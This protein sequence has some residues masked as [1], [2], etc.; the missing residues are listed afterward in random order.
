MNIVHIKTMATLYARQGKCKGPCNPNNCPMS[1]TISPNDV[2]GCCDNCEEDI[3]KCSL[4]QGN[5]TKCYCYKYAERY[6]KRVLVVEEI[7]S[8]ALVEYLI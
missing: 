7:T 6:L 1:E 3:R 2:V 4:S 8:D 5:F